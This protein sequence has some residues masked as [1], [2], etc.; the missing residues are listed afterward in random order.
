MLESNF[1]TKF[2]QLSDF[3]TLAF[4]VALIALFKVINVLQKKKVSFSTRMTTGTVLGLVLGVIVQAVAKFP[5][6]PKDIAWISELSGWYGF[7]GGGF[8]DLLKMLVIPLIL[9]SITRV[10][11]NMKGDNLGKLTTK[12]IG[13]LIGLTVFAAITGIV[14]A[15]LFNLGQGFDAGN[16]TAEIREAVS[17]SETIR[18][19]LPSNIVS[20]MAEGNIVGVVIFSAFIGTSIRRLSKKHADTIEPFVKWV[21]AFYKIII[22]VTMTIIKFMPYAVIALLANTIISNGIGVLASVG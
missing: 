22:S 11:M 13:S 6:S 14:L 4:I 3:R 10:I 17:L 2:L 18:A 16:N 12:T 21:E 5:D 9:L 15:L 20:S 1:F 19:L 8:I 7:V